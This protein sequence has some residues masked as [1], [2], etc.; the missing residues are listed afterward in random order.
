MAGFHPTVEDDV[1]VILSNKG[2]E[3]KERA[4][5]NDIADNKR[6]VIHEVTRNNSKQARV[7]CRFV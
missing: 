2:L 5:S 3:L 7:S 6:E 4:S 1:F